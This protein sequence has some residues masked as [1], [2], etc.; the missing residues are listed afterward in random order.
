MTAPTLDIADPILRCRDVCRSIGI[1]QRTLYRWVAE[2]NF[3]APRQL[4]PRRIGWY[5]AD[6]AAWKASRPSAREQAAA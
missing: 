6:L 4:G 3:P 2:G 5:T 1:S